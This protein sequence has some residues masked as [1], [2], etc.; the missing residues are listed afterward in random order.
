MGWFL[1]HL[2]TLSFCQCICTMLLMTAVYFYYVVYLFSW[3]YNPVVVFFTAPVA[4]F[5]LLILEVS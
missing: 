1:L 3:R 4:G 2:V 5:N